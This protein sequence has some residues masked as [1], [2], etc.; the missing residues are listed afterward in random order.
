MSDDFESRERLQELFAELEEL[1]NGPTKVAT[2]EEAA[3]LS[4]A[5]GDEALQYEAR[6]AVLEASIFAGFPEKAL[7]AFSWISAACDRSPDQFPESDTLLGLFIRRVDLLWAYKW[8]VQNTHGFPQITRRQVEKTLDDM[9][10]RYAK[11]GY[12]LRPVWMNRTRIAMAMDAGTEGAA[13]SFARWRE[14]PRD[15]YADCAACEQH[16][17]V[18]YH[19]YR[20]DLEQATQAAG[21]LLRGELACAEVPH[22]TY[23]RLVVPTWLGGDHGQATFY[24][25]RGYE[26]CR[27]NRDFLEELAEIVEFDVIRGE[28]DEALRVFQSHAQ[29]LADSRVGSR[30]L[31]WF[32][33][34]AG[35]FERLLEDRPE[36]ELRLPSGF[37]PASGGPSYAVQP[38]ADWAARESRQLAE[39]FD[40]RNGNDLVTTRVGQI[41]DRMRSASHAS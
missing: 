13:E 25:E 12:S 4:D 41:R 40:R 24:R 8:V 14:A 2:A 19:L 20:G 31:R 6:M 36:V 30:R 27:G 34:L 16:F 38:L 5:V 15:L 26:L 10:T 3:A 33:T 28:L 18:D 39:A 11:N 21:P 9:A 37:G 23:L 32:A 7:V 29:W 17:Q 22:M 1:P 35:L